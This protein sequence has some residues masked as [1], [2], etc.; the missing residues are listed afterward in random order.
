MEFSSVLS[1]WL[2]VLDRIGINGTVIAT[3]VIPSLL[4]VAL[5]IFV[6]YRTQSTHYFFARLWILVNGKRQTKNTEMNEFFERRGDLMQFRFLTGIPVSTFPASL[7]LMEWADAQEIEIGKI[8]ACGYYFDTDALAF[9]K[10][11]FPW[12]GT[13]WIL[14]ILAMLGVYAVMLFSIFAIANQVVMRFKDSDHRWFL[15]GQGASVKAL[16]TDFRFG[17]EDCNKDRSLIA[18]R[19]EWSKENV[20][21]VC[22]TFEDPKEKSF[23][24]D[25]IREQRW[26]AGVLIVVFLWGT[27][28]AFFSARR[29]G[30]A[31]SLS[32]KLATKENNASETKKGHKR[33]NDAETK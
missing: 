20:D 31:L 5:I 13:P 16:S 11:S 8:H 12:K 6:C 15:Y 28:G 26:T 32:K 14:G 17:I 3:V 24:D 1:Q 21:A 23:F 10:K 22:K 19:T 18:K 29:A 2:G 4:A 25:A 30:S 33:S 7:R 27:L 9:N